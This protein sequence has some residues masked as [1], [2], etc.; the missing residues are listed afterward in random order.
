MA[1]HQWTPEELKTLTVLGLSITPHSD[2]GHSWGYT[3]QNRDWVGPF[4][5]PAAA[6]H[7]A[8]TEALQALQFKSDYSWVLFAHP[9]ECW[10]FTGNTFGWEQIERPQ[11]LPSQ[12]IDTLDAEEQE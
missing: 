4:T 11:R 5:S 10:Q 6:I 1:E 3:W 7:M 8:F 9:G 12:A 2:P